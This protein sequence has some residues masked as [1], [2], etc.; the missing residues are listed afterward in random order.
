MI[1]IRAD[2]NSKIGMGHVM[3]CLSVAKKLMEKGEQVLFLTADE[4]PAPVL[5]REK[6]PYRVLHTDY[7]RMEEELSV[8][9]PVIREQKPGAVLIDSY[10]VTKQY[11]CSV[12]EAARTVYMDDLYAFSYPVDMLINYNIYADDL[13]YRKDNSMAGTTFL[14]GPSYAPLREE[15]SD[16][17]YTVKGEAE[18]ILITTGGSDSYN[19]AGGFLQEALQKE[20]TKYKIY[21]V[22]SGSLNPHLKELSFLA[23]AH[24]NIVLHKNVTHMAELMRECDVAISAGGS[25]MYELSAVGVP[26]ITFS[27]A[28][29]QEKIA[30]TFSNLGY[31]AWGGNY[32][33]DQEKMVPA[34]IRIMAELCADKQ[35]RMAYSSKARTLVDGRGAERVAD[36]ILGN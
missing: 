30:E 8:S 1:V 19:L 33:S 34:V 22:V 11:L 12:R 25:T 7:S 14:L 2:A 27:F 5:L 3:R 15:F 29:N 24:E 32:L 20:S 23:E 36:A 10:Y 35:R 17:P 21:H 6:I 31:A 26:V 16:V 13:C 4:N 9:M 18:R 28:K